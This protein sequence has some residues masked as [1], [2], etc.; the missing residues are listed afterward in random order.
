MKKRL[1]RH[2]KWP[3]QRSAVWERADDRGLSDD[4][5]SGI[6]RNIACSEAETARKMS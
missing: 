5:N 6:R 2:N 4:L 1:Q 3:L